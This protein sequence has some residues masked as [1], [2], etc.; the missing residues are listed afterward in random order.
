MLNYSE[1]YCDKCKKWYTPN[2]IVECNKCPK[3]DS[4][5]YGDE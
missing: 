3:C 4:K 1:R 2:D 5:V